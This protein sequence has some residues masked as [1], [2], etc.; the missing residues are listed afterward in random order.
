MQDLTACSAEGSEKGFL[1]GSATC[2]RD[3][4]EIHLRFVIKCS[5]SIFCAFSSKVDSYK[6]SRLP[7]PCRTRCP[8]SSTACWFTRSVFDSR[9]DSMF[10]TRSKD[11]I[12]VGTPTLLGLNNG[13]F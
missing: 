13:K 6:S 3:I 11:A 10:S 2:C 4:L 9:L 12:Y 5:G 7:F 1:A 8:S